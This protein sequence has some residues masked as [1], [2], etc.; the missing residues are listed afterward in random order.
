MKNTLCWFVV[1]SVAICLAAESAEATC[2]GTLDATWAGVSPGQGVRVN[3]YPGTI[4]SPGKKTSLSTVGGVYNFRKTGGDETITG[5]DPVGSTDPPNLQTHCI[6]LQNYVGGSEAWNVCTL[7]EAPDPNTLLGGVTIDA[8][9]E[10]RLQKLFF[11]YPDSSIYSLS[12]SAKSKQAAARQIA[13]WEIVFEH[14]K[15]LNATDSTSSFYVTNDGGAGAVANTMLSAVGA[16]SWQKGDVMPELYA[17]VDRVGGASGDQ[18]Q[19]WIVPGG[20]DT[21]IPEPVTMLGMF[22]GLGSVGAYIKRRRM[23]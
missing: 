12:G 4:G 6:D 15:G 5:L 19:V 17:F 13:V 22:L 21:Y 7:D 2:Y 10:T 9:K 1:T 23:M 14:W 16:K 8:T 20:G 3:A 11:L 18:D